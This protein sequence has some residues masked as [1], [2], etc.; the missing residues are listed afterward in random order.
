MLVFL[1][2]GMCKNKTNTKQDLIVHTKKISLSPCISTICEMKVDKTEDATE[3][4]IFG[5]DLF[6]N[7]DAQIELVLAEKTRLEASSKVLPM[8]DD[9]LHR[10]TAVVT[11]Y[12]FLLNAKQ[13]Q[14]N[15]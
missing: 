13:S 10:Y 6:I 5:R 7:I 14:A 15:N 9:V 11:K 3:R 8:T 1:L 2:S 4:A 12:N